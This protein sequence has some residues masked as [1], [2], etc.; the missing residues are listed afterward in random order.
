MKILALSTALAATSVVSAFDLKSPES[1]AQ[2]WNRS[3]APAPESLVPDSLL[4]ASLLS[5][6]KYLP[7]DKALA[8]PSEAPKPGFGIIPR[9]RNS[10][11]PINGEVYVVPSPQVDPKVLRAKP[12]EM[13][14]PGA[15]SWI[16]RGQQFWLIPIDSPAAP[17]SE[18]K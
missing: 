2:E 15:K 6:R 9:P 12:G 7:P 11:P 4:D 17:A 3:L 5:T 8:Q 13:P 14:P 1:V 18:T 16:Y 10:V